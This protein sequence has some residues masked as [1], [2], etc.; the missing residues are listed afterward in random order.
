MQSLN[1]LLQ[2]CDCDLIRQ[3]LF[4]LVKL[5]LLLQ[6]IYLASQLVDIVILSCDRL[7]S[8][9]LDLECECLQIFELLDRYEVILIHKCGLVLLLLVVVVV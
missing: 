8:F 3:S 9:F 2:I 6:M 7:L 5:V 1:F 4:I